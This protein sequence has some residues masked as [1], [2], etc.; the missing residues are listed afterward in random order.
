MRERGDED[1]RGKI[2][3]AERSG[4]EPWTAQFYNEYSDSLVIFIRMKHDVFS[5]QLIQFDFTMYTST[6]INE[7][8]I[9]YVLSRLAR[10][11]WKW[12]FFFKLFR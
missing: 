8:G 9:T 3:V 5:I 2:V 12:F 7:R 1:V 11:K 6:T 4:I 10:S